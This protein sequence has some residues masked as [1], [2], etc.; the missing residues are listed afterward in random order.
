MGGSEELAVEG[1]IAFPNAEDLST[2]LDQLESAWQHCLRV[3]AEAKENPDFGEWERS[4]RD[5]LSEMHGLVDRRCG[6]IARIVHDLV[7]KYQ[8]GW[9]KVSQRVSQ[10][11]DGIEEAKSRMDSGGWQ[12]Q[13]KDSVS[14][15][16]P[17]QLDAAAEL[18]D[19]GDRAGRA[20]NAIAAVNVAILISTQQAIEDVERFLLGQGGAGAVNGAAVNVGVLRDW[21]VVALSPNASWKEGVHDMGAHLDDIRAS[22][23]S[24]ESD[25][26]WP[27]LAEGAGKGNTVDDSPNE[28]PPDLNDVDPQPGTPRPPR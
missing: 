4:Y 1:H 15:L 27:A 22:T 7:E 19:I 12:G 2:S 11:R 25:G 14:A 9:E 20:C 18:S 8:P 3:D 28:A 6:D 5:A 24:L 17:I 13:A 26:S 10:V 23:S 16:L 21:M